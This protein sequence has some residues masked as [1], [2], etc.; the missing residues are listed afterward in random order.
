MK[1]EQI[2][3]CLMLDEEL[4]TPLDECIKMKLREDS[5]NPL[6]DH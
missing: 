2:D 1:P 4:L 6:G 5:K 3:I